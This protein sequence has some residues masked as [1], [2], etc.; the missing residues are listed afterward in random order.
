VVIDGVL[1]SV[2]NA[3]LPAVNSCRSHLP[4]SVGF[5]EIGLD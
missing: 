3:R 4:L 5:K 1:D 2:T